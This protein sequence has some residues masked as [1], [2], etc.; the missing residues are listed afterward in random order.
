[1]SAGGNENLLFFLREL[2]GALRPEED[3]SVDNFREGWISIRVSVG[4]G[5]ARWSIMRS[6]S[7]TQLEQMQESALAGEAAALLEQLRRGAKGE[8]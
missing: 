7:R 8:P 5:A 4:D 6:F 2:L 1:M 3:F